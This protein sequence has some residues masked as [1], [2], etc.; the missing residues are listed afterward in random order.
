MNTLWET[1]QDVFAQVDVQIAPISAAIAGGAL[2][3]VGLS[4]RD[5]KRSRK[6]AESLAAER[7]RFRNVSLN[8]P[9]L[10]PSFRDGRIDGLYAEFPARDMS[11][12]AVEVVAF[13]GG[14]ELIVQRALITVVYSI[15]VIRPR[16]Y[17]VS[18]PLGDPSRPVHAIGQEL[19]CRLPPNDQLK[20]SLPKVLI[21]DISPVTAF[22]D[23][24]PGLLMM[25]HRAAFAMIASVGATAWKSDVSDVWSTGL[26]H[27]LKRAHARSARH[28]IYD[29]LPD[30][31]VDEMAPPEL[32]NLLRLWSS[33]PVEA[34]NARRL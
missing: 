26:K 32:R 13:S 8:V 16:V 20:W 25:H 14:D 5:S 19:P 24:K 1:V 11:T 12:G 3:V 18:V 30:L 34:V 29:S 15:G 2:I 17:R 7:G 9:E 4:R 28:Y 23:D 27:A 31:M 21:R 33:D 10:K 6:L 22:W